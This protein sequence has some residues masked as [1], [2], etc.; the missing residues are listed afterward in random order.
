MYITKVSGH[1]QATVAIQEALRKI[2]QTVE[3]PAVN[4]FGY[5]YPL[6]EKVVN[7]A[8]MSVIRL[9][10]QVWDYMYD[11]PKIINNTTRIKKFLFRKSHQKIDRLF[12]RYTPDTVVCTQAFPCGM[13]ADYKMA[14]GLDT[15][16][17]GVLTDFAPHSYWINP[18]IDYYIV[19][20]EDTRQ[21]FINKG[22]SEDKIKVFGIPM[23]AKFAERLN[24]QEIAEKL[25]LNLKTPTVLV[26]GGGQGLG[27]IK[28]ILQ[29]LDTIPMPFQVIVIAGK[30]KKILSSLHRYA[31]ITK[32][33]VL[34][35]EFANNVDELMEISNL[36]ITK[37]G[38][39]TTC[40]C[41]TKGLP[42]AIVNPIPGQE[43]RNMDFLIQ[44]G[45]AIRISYTDQVGI[46]VEN[47]LKSPERL[48]KMRRC[49]LKHSKP[50]AAFD[51]AR[52]ILQGSSSVADPE[53]PSSIDLKNY[54]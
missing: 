53:I 8:Y 42:M 39:M 29:S 11:N 23:R 21:R 25:G 4:G 18:G 44:E 49:A 46:E 24:K 51:I 17:I 5:T 27:P 28:T 10:P 48:A 6:L 41:L 33:K 37:P 40:E 9:C 52:L 14:H 16:L 12:Q 22:V 30:N 47:L 1:R 35:Y 13:V 31:E 2:D 50:H 38:G 19:P 7:S 54:V 36:I 20:S 32:H 34:I 15:T 3:A 45:V 43:V 26:M